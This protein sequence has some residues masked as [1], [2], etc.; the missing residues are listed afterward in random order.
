MEC[1]AALLLDID[2]VGLV[3]GRGSA[4][5][6]GLVDAYV[7]D[8]PYAASSFLSVAIARVFGAA[9]GGRSKPEELASRELELEAIVSPVRSPEATWPDRLF[10]P[11]GYRVQQSALGDYYS[12]LRFGDRVRILPDPATE[13]RGLAGKVGEVYGQTTPSSTKPTII[14]IPLKDYAV[15]V[16]F[17]DTREQH[18]FPEHLVELVDHNPGATLRLGDMEYVRNADGSW[19]ERKTK[20]NV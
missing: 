1:T 16:F 8:R 7:N 14:G 9:L 11:L 17:D 6:S 15:G 20:P 18:W 2:P 19:A 12:R 13:E 5:D 3:R 10:A 4:G